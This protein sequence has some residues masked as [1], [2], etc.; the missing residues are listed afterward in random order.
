MEFSRFFLEFL[1]TFFF[2]PSTCVWSATE[3]VA[4][5]ALM[6]A[7]EFELARA[8]H[9]RLYKRME[10]VARATRVTKKIL[11]PIYAKVIFFFFLRMETFFSQF[12]KKSIFFFPAIN[13]C[14]VAN[15]GCVGT[16][17]SISHGRPSTITGTF[18]K[19]NI[20]KNR[21]FRI[22]FM[23]NLKFFQFFLCKN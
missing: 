16:C 2:Q 14:D 13:S 9:F 6:L 12:S 23:Q 21:K 5:N 17:T 11:R 22:F 19:S 18:F 4:T 8:V 1:L 7:P 20:F 15:G 3:N 10:R